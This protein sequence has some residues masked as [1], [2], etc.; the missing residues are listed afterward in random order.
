[1]A[2]LNV[3]RKNQNWLADEMGYTKGYISQIVN[4]DCKIS[5]AFIERLLL[6][7]RMEFR[8]LFYCDGRVDTREQYGEIFVLDGQNYNKRRF[9][10]E[11]R[12][13]ASYAGK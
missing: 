5:A 7:T 12:A 6:V 3:T 11:I 8:D 2:Y 10:E 13:G 4:D 9:F 1:M